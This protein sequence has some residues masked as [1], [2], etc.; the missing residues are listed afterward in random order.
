[1]GRPPRTLSIV[2]S[3]PCCFVRV[4]SDLRLL[5]GDDVLGH[6]F[7]FGSLCVSVCLCCGCAVKPLSD[8][9]CFLEG[10]RYV[11]FTLV[12]V[13]VFHVLLLLLQLRGHVD[14]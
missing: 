1:M 10:G 2:T 7:L 3:N 4:A 5:R 14:L 9:S 6:L 12:C 13:C 8:F 11:C